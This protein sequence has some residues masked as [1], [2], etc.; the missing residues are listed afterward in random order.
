MLLVLFA[1][2]ETIKAERWKY[3]MQFTGPKMIWNVWSCNAALTEQSIF[4]AHL[5]QGAGKHAIKIF[6]GPVEGEREFA[7]GH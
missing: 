2:P 5:M 3:C 6:F 7:P 1:Q 4:S